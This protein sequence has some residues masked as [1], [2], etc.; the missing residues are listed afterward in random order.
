MMN[1]TK[2]GILLSVCMAL[3]VP[4]MALAAE[5]EKELARESCEADYETEVNPIGTLTQNEILE[6]QKN[7]GVCDSCPTPY[8]FSIVPHS[9]EITRITSR[10]KGE[11]DRGVVAEVRRRVDTSTVLTYEKGRSVENSYSVSIGFDKD[12]V[13][14]EMGYDVSFSTEETAS[15]SVD[16]PANKLASINL[17]DIYDVTKFDVKTTYVYD[18]VP[19]TYTYENG[20]GWAQQWTNFGFSAKIW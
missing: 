14:G 13:S 11:I 20:T 9:H 4:N 19:I 10:Y 7:N 6:L 5:T 16:V 3:V 15:Y 12:V 1:K 18:T 2:V 17:Y 8:H